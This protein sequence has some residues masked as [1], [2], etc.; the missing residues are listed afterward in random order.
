MGAFHHSRVWVWFETGIWDRQ[1]QSEEGGYNPPFCYAS[2][3]LGIFIA[4]FSWNEA[5]FLRREISNVRAIKSCYT[6]TKKEV[7]VPC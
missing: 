4:S 3:N 5:Q 2:K 1:G 7:I 6:L